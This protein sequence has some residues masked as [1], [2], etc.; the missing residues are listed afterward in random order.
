MELTPASY[1]VLGLLHIG[2]RSGYE[3]KRFMEMSARAV[4]LL[5]VRIPSESGYAPG[6]SVWTNEV[7]QE[8]GLRWGRITRITTMTDTQRELAFLRRLADRGITEAEAQPIADANVGAL[9]RDHE[10]AARVPLGEVGH[11]L[12]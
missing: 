4:A 6:E 12:G 2:A 1:V 10:L 5:D 11:R 8:I 7:V 9:Q 3:V